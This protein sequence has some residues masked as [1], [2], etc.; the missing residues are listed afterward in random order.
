MD[1]KHLIKGYDIFV[2]GEW[3]LSPFEHLYELACRDVIQEHINDFNE[4]EKEEIKKLDRILIER[5][6]LFYKALKGFLEAEQKNK[7]KSH[8]WWYLNEVVEG[9]LNPQVN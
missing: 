9:K 5:A 6:P 1:N 2:N 8:W 3:D 7:P 4:T